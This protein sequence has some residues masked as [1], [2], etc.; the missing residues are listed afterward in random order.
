MGLY[1]QYLLPLLVNAICKQNPFT[2]Q[3][4]KIVPLAKG[5]VLEI[6]IGS[7]LNLPFYQKEQV[8][9][10]TAIDPSLAVWKQNRTKVDQLGFPFEFHQ[11]GAEKMPFANHSFDSIVTTYTFCTIPD[12]EMAMQELRRVLK[13]TGVL[14]FCEHGKASDPSIQKWQNR[15]N[16]FWKHFGGGCNLNRDI[17]NLIQ[18]NGFNIKELNAQYIPGWKPLSYNYWG[19]ATP[20]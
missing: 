16:P 17:P 14:I 11:V 9:E 1:D 6:G 2:D 3:R 10:L 8:T 18:T 20:L 19:M 5:K 13:P 4:S 12:D 15:L 7:G